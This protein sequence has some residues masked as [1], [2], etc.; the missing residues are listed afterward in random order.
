MLILSCLPEGVGDG[1]IVYVVHLVDSGVNQVWVGFGQRYGGFCQ[2]R[3]LALGLV[4]AWQS[5]GNVEI[6]R[7]PEEIP[8]SRESGEQQTYCSGLC[9]QPGPTARDRPGLSREDK[10]TCAWALS[11]G[12]EQSFG[13]AKAG[14]G[15]VRRPNLSGSEGGDPG[16][17][18]PLTFLDCR[19]QASPPS[20]RLKRRVPGVFCLCTYS[21]IHASILFHQ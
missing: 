20:T 14:A 5:R 19:S 10:P 7:D 17:P 3:R 18:P 21:F 6:P 1:N 16:L 12:S 4:G 11:P 15:G 13:R 2:G 8:R 9:R